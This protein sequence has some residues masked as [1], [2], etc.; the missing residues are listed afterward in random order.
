MSA[1]HLVRRI[2]PARAI[3]TLLVLGAVRLGILP[4]SA[5]TVRV[6]PAPAVDISAEAGDGRDGRPRPAAASWAQGVPAQ[7]RDSA[8]S[9]RWRRRRRRPTMTRVGGGAPPMPKRCASP[10]PRKITFGR[11]LQIYFSVA[12]I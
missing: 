5:E 9:G 10:D 7:G 6:V 2:V 1:S 12:T 8:A 11:L 4:S 3:G